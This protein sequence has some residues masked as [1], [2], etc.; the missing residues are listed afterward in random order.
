MSK[1]GA[2]ASDTAEKG[3][4]EK[5]TIMKDSI[6]LLTDLLLNVAG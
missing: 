3:N 6:N 1:I 4:P 2:C 5:E